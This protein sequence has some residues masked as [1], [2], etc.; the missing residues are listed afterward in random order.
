MITLALALVLAAVP[1]QHGNDYP[2]TAPP[3]VTSKTFTLGA[4]PQVGVDTLNGD[5]TVVADGGSEVRFTATERIR[6]EDQA[7]LQRAQRDVKLDV[8]S[9]SD[10]LTLYVDG[11][12]RNQHGWFWDQDGRGYEVAYSFELH[13]PAGTQVDLRTVNGDEKVTGIAGGFHTG[14]VNGNLD[15]EQMQGAGRASTV[16]GSLKVVYRDNPTADSSFSTVN[17]K[18]SLF[19]R[20]DLNADVHYSTVSGSI[21]TDF[22]SAQSMPVDS[23]SSRA[24]MREWSSGRSRTVEIGHG[25]PQIKVSTV[26]GDVFLHRGQ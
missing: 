13:V 14:S 17:G 9:T 18:V 4:T 22:P 7:A 12:F 1:P 15:L 6:A 11:P 21:Y 5:I 10:R 26:N 23:R 20:P 16:N 3:Q 8:T 19:L 2:V 25:G 24:G